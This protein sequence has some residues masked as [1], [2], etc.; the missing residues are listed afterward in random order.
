M[1]REAQT[2][3][4][5][6]EGRFSLGP[7]MSHQ[8]VVEH[9]LGGTYEKPVQQMREYVGIL[10]VLLAGASVSLNGQFARLNQVR[11]SSRSE[12][13]VPLEIAALRPAMLQLAVEMKLGTVTFMT[14]PQT[15]ERRTIPS[16][17]PRIAA[18]FPV[19][20]ADD[21]ESGRA[22][23]DGALAIY[24]HTPAYR[25]MMD[26]EGVQGPGDN[27]IVGGEKELAR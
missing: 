21:V 8:F 22:Y 16:G 17:V 6:C 9:M 15:L 7:G 20:L 13:E 2:V 12:F 27:A 23:I 26:E 10:K 1:A 24:N 18:V 19:L 3:G 25:S 4:L 14:G 11:L 5:A